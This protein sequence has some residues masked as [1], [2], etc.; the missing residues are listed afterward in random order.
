MARVRRS[1]SPEVQLARLE[2]KHSELKQR[3][4]VLSRRHGLSEGE[5]LEMQRLKRE[6]LAA[7]DRLQAL[8]AAR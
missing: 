4:A 3:C 8:R 2:A 6:K 5:Q 7:K 1:S